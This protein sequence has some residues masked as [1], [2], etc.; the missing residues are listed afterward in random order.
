MRLLRS[1]LYYAILLV[2][3][4]PV[5]LAC[6]IAWPVT[7]TKWRYNVFERPYMR[8]AVQCARVLCGL[9]FE[10]RGLENVPDVKER[11]VIFCKHQ[12]AWETLFLPAYI[13]GYIAYVYKASLHWIPFFGWA[14]KSMHM[15]PIDRKN[16]RLAFEQIMK[17]GSRLL[18]SGWWIG[19]F[20]EGTR[21]APGAASTYKTGGARFAVRQKTLVLPIAVN[22]GE[23]WAKNSL[24]KTPG[25]IIVS[26][27]PAI[28]TVGRDYSQVNRLASDWIESEVRRIGNP[29]F[30]GSS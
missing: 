19:I 21:V 30:Y 9:D 12:S 18:D 5:G 1:F 28:E 3:A 22:S 15:I 25:K 11:V 29:R 10:V 23:F 2:A 13:P 14:A 27:G 20:P 8:F 6:L 16:G 4:V 17:E 24:E 26:I 7:S